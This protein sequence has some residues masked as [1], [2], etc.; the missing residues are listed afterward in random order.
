MN[1]LSILKYMKTLPNFGKYHPI[2]T[3]GDSNV[4]EE[5]FD[6]YIVD[7]MLFIVG[8]TITDI[9]SGGYKT[10]TM[11]DPSAINNIHCDDA[12]EAD[13]SAVTD[14]GTT[15]AALHTAFVTKAKEII[16]AC[17]ASEN[18]FGL[19]MQNVRLIVGE[20]SIRLIT[21][22]G[23]HVNG[24]LLALDVHEYNIGNI[25]GK[26]GNSINSK[27]RIFTTFDQVAAIT[28]PFADTNFS[29][30]K[31]HAGADIEAACSQYRINH[32]GSYGKGII[33]YYRNEF[34]KGDRVW[35]DVEVVSK[36][37][38][39]NNTVPE[40]RKWFVSLVNKNSDVPMSKEAKAN[41]SWAE[42]DPD[43]NTLIVTEGE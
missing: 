9:G 24:D 43:T 4:F 36:S 21:E 40:T 27:S 14:D 19:P 38:N 20:E 35:S 34:A 15:D 12:L 26:P 31:S 17:A 28:I 37:G 42:Y 10:L 18:N 16:P 11:I 7:N 33:P 5:Y 8:V 32:F 1:A 22:G 13:F 39:P 2:I 41:N 30:L 6:Y 23:I 3:I 25:V 29:P